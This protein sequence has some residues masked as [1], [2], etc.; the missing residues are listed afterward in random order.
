MVL[1]S[2]AFLSDCEAFG[3]RTNTQTVTA[4]FKMKRNA[5]KLHSPPWTVMESTW[6]VPNFAESPS[7]TSLMSVWIYRSR[8]LE[9]CTATFTLK[10][11]YRE[12]QHHTI[13]SIFCDWTPLSISWA[14][15]NMMRGWGCVKG[16]C[17]HSLIT[18]TCGTL[19]KV[20]HSSR[21]F[22][23]GPWG[24]QFRWIP[25]HFETRSKKNWMIALCHCLWT[26][27]QYSQ[28][29]CNNHEVCTS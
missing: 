15:Q 18:E 5:T 4:V 23:H 12:Y 24:L 29:F 1:D 7:M 17:I 20:R 9:R 11:S 6:A 14:G 13:T 10:V 3:K 28:C 27:S 8:E 16:A 22:H 2:P 25:F 19:G 26:D 21:A